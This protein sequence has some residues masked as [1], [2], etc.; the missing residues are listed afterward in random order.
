MHMYCV[1]HSLVPSP[2][3]RLGF[4]GIALL[5]GFSMKMTIFHHCLQLKVSMTTGKCKCNF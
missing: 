5:N 1:N 3:K 4:I 2:T